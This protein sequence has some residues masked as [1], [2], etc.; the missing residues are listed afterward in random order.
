MYIYKFKENDLERV[1]S[2]H[3]VL[4]HVPKPS[5]KNSIWNGIEKNGR[6]VLFNCCVVVAFVYNR[7][8]KRILWH[9]ATIKICKQFS[10]ADFSYLIYIF[11]LYF[12]I[13]P[14]SYLTI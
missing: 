12:T 11:I 5:K 8:L 6:R 13:F 3:Y 2:L 9:D 1:S 7:R 14:F 10:K 4:Q